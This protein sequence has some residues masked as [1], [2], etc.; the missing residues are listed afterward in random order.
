MG[1]TSPGEEP[2]RHLSGPRRARSLAR[3]L[4]VQALYQFQV[5]PAPWVDI[6]RQFAADREAEAVD[7]E[8]FT[9]LMSAI[10]PHTDELDQKLTEWSDL[11]PAELDPTEHAILWVGLCELADF[12]EIPYRVA[13]DEAVQLAKQFG[14]TDGH[15]FVNAV[16]DR[17]ARAMRSAEYSRPTR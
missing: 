5:N 9:Q 16:M 12:P 7:R 10:A 13:I 6:Q 4:V 15:K 2:L 14:A 3:R 1:S 11:S 8:Y 17:A